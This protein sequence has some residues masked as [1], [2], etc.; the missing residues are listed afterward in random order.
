MI[1]IAEI[2]IVIHNRAFSFTLCENILEIVD[3]KSEYLGFREVLIK[4]DFVKN[5]SYLAEQAG[6]TTYII[7]I[8]S[9]NWGNLTTKSV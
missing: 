6:K 4:Y 2:K 5:H 9:Q 8:D 1:S 3:Q 7:R